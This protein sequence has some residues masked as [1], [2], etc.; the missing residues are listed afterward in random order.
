MANAD[1]WIQTSQ[2]LV[3][4]DLLWQQAIGIEHHLLV[5][6]QGD[7]PNW[8]AEEQALHQFFRMGTIDLQ[9]KHSH[10]NGWV[11]AMRYSTLL[12]DQLWLMLEEEQERVCVVQLPNPP[13]P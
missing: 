9:A 7:A 13:F 3:L 2:G 11:R 12:A 5:V 8:T 6:H 10:S 1:Y 4:D